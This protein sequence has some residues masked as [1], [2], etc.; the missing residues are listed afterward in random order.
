MT[1]LSAAECITPA[2]ARTKLILFTPFRKGRTWK[3]SATAYVSRAGVM[4]FPCPLIYLAALPWARQAGMTAVTLLVVGTLVFT[5]ITL[6][7]FHLC[8]RLQFAYFDIV[9]NRGEFV[10]PA[11]RKYGRSSFAWTGFKVLFGTIATLVFAIPIAAFIRHLIPLFRS[12]ADFKPGQPPPVQF[13]AAFYGGYAIFMLVLG[14]FYVVSSLLGDFVIPSLALEGTG[15][16]E[17]FRRMVE[18]IR[19]EPGQFTIYTLL[20]LGLGFTAYIGVTIAW[21]IL[22]IVLTLIVGGVVVLIGFLLHLAGVSSIVLSVL[23]FFAIGLWYIF[24]L[25][26]V[27]FPLGAVLTFLDAY[28]LYFLGGRYPM[29]GDLLDHSTPPPSIAHAASYYPPPPPI[30]EP[31]S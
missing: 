15:V 25:Y 20:K 7:L 4:F 24:L 11:W 19:R 29:L 18:L 8:S 10:A 30:G 22:F 6:V 12:M 16:S 31:R 28:G 27:V 17:A 14:G 21:E 13:M 3:L 26:S 5:A 2:I 9:V 23:G 1:P